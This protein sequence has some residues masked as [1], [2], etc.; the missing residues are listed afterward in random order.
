MHLITRGVAAMR[1]GQTSLRRLAIVPAL[2]TVWGIWS[3]SHRYGGS[4]VA[5]S[6]WL[7]G[8]RAGAMRGW[9]LLVTFLV[10]CGSEVALAVSPALS[11]N[12]NFSAAYLLLS[13]GFTGVFVGQYLRY[14]HALRKGMPSNLGPAH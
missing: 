10:K 6:G 5:W 9:L 14:L 11:A 1:P 12:G 4:L 7:A 3:I 2:F 13:G 8:I